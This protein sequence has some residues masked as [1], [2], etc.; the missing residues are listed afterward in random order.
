MPSAGPAM[1]KF[2]W[3]ALMCSQVFLLIGQAVFPRTPP[4]STFCSRDTQARPD[5]TTPSPAGILSN[6]PRQMQANGS[7][8]SVRGYF[9]YPYFKR[10]CNQHGRPLRLA[11]SHWPRSAILDRMGAGLE[12]AAGSSILQSERKADLRRPLQGHPS[13]GVPRGPSQGVPPEV[14]V[15]RSL[16]C[17]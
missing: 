1:L 7:N 16:S 2:R 3:E 15:L 9:A 11:L 8:Y 5:C 17:I 13:E 6:S 12:G 14:R 10:H 4:S